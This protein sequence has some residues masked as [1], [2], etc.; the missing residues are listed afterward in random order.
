[1]TFQFIFAGLTIACLFYFL[2]ITRNA[3][4]QRVFIALFFGIG[5]LFICN[6]DMTNT[7]AH[8]LGIGRGVDFI[9]YLSTLFL[10]FICF[11]LYL[12]FKVYDQKL[13]RITR[14]LALHNPIREET[15]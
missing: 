3:A 14:E 12:R 5:L 9:L 10:F 13:T 6:P 7:L 15:K 1:M 8:S 11:N 4:Y 2:I